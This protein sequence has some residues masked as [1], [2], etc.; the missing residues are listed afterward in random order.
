MSATVGRTRTRRRGWLVAGALLVAGDQALQHVF[1]GDGRL[2]GHRIA[3]F[4]PPVFTEMQ[5]LRIQELRDRA[6]RARSAPSR[7]SI[8]AE[9]GWGPRPARAGSPGAYDEFGARRSTVALGAT[10]RS[11][12]RRV[13]AVGCSF[14]HG[15]EVAAGD[16]WPARLGDPRDDVEVANLGFGAYGL[17]QALLRL[18]RD[19]L[20]LEP[21]EVWLGWLPFAS[22][23]ITTHLPLLQNHWTLI[24][25]FKPRFQLVDGALH[26]RPNPGPTPQ[27]TLALFDDQPR[28]LE[29]LGPDDPW[30]ARAPWAYAPRGSAWPHRSGLARLALT[31]R[32]SRGR[33]PRHFIA[34]P[35]SATAQLV[36]ALVQAAADDA[37]RV[38]ARFRL[39]VLPSRADLRE[40]NGPAPHYWAALQ[41]SLVARGIEVVDLGP[42]LLAAG[43]LDDP[44]AWMPGGH[45][46]PRT[47]GL[48]ADALALRLDD[49]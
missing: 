6:G 4:D 38:G 40:L 2:A 43:V 15:E 1:L 34:D 12:V 3:P 30:I 46:A 13:V 26:L 47:N 23:R 16:S 35:S 19:G 45:Y 5:A 18:R 27:A 8:G 20:K 17:D 24:V 10:P 32:E 29:A 39:L 44:S 33:H 49:E 48:I 37:A 14:T 11:G 36:V 21:D 28:L 41:D 22:T 7:S 42:E 25:A 31:A 9:L